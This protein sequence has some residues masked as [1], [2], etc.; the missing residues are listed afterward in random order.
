M[1][2]SEEDV[3]RAWGLMRRIGTCMLCTH[4]GKEIRSRPMAAHVDR[5][6]HAIYFLID[7]AGHKDDE[8]AR[9]PLVCLA[10]ADLHG[11]KYVSV[12]GRAAVSNDRA[13]IKELWSTPA[14]AWWRTPDEPSIR[15]LT[16]T[17]NDAQYWDSPGTVMTY[18]R[19][20]AAVVADKRPAV[21]D[22][23]K[24]RM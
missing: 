16:V 15:V 4:D 11:Q 2:G 12:T 10:F 24:V 19:M 13:K 22:R 21:G 8:I 23:A 17:P 7:E 18:V 6:A 9:E 3:D 1:S 14:K 20:L 5:D